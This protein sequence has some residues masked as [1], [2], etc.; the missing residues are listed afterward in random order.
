MT[1]GTGIGGGIFINNQILH[2]GTFRGGEFGFMITQGGICKHKNDAGMVGALYH[3]R[4]K[5]ELLSIR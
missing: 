1:I 3:F 4:R 2:G 5:E